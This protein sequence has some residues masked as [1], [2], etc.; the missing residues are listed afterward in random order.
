MQITNHATDAPYQPKVL[1]FFC[2][3]CC[4]PNTADGHLSF[5]EISDSIT[6]VHFKCARD[7]TPEQLRLG[8]RN[9]ADG[10]LI[11]GCLV[12]R[13]RNSATDL[14]VLRSL[15]R[16]QV[17]VKNLGLES[18]R[19]REEWVVQGTTDHLEHIVADFVEQLRLLGPISRPAVATAGLADELKS[20]EN[21]A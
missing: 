8:F 11:C 9:G 3:H 16:N 2:S 7:V 5:A 17:T 6:S 10:V 15:Y 4:G 14:E 19:L 20:L 18:E 21:E 1:V 12:R 13:C